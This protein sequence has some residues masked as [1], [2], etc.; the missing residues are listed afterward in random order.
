MRRAADSFSSNIATAAERDTKN[1]A[2][3]FID[4]GWSAQ[5]RA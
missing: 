3:L 1:D 2:V 4:D 5:L